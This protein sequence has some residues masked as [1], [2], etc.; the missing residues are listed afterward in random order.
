[1]CYISVNYVLGLVV[2]PEEGSS[3]LTK[4][5]KC[6][7]LSIFMTMGKVIL[8]AGDIVQHRTH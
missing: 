3:L 4:P 5:K 2:S 6:I 7:V 1:M 8:N